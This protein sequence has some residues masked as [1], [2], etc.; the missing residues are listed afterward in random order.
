MNHNTAELPKKMKVLGKDFF[1]IHLLKGIYI[2]TNIL[3]SMQ[4]YM[5]VGH[6][7]QV[8]TDV[9]RGVPK[10]PLHIPNT[11]FYYTVLLSFTMWSLT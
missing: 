3:K 5:Y 7:I 4:W 9:G 6:Y 2:H 10:A 1:S 8:F 11:I